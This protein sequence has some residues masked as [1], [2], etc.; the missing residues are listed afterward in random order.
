MA[1]CPDAFVKLLFKV[2][3]KQTWDKICPWYY[4]YYDYFDPLKNYV[5]MVIRNIPLCLVVCLCIFFILMMIEWMFDWLARNPINGEQLSQRF[6]F[7]YSLVLSDLISLN[8]LLLIKI[9]S[10]GEEFLTNWTR[11]WAG[12]EKYFAN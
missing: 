1:S 11:R 9:M 12:N 3:F 7:F 8:E 10:Y 5:I 2:L 6:F 4:Y